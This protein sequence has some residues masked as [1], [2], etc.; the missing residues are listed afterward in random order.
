MAVDKTI[1]Q[2]DPN[3]SIDGTEEIA[4]EKSGVN[5]K[6]T[7]TAL[8]TWIT[9]TFLTDG[10]GTTANGTAVDLG[11]VITSPRTLNDLSGNGGSFNVNIQDDPTIPE[12]LTKTEINDSRVYSFVGIEDGAGNPLTSSESIVSSEVLVA[13]IIL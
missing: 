1:G 4:I 11:G 5:F 9:S 7:Y 12:A 2:L 8:K 6:N 10:N 3:P 13:S